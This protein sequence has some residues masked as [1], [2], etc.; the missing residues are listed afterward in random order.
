MFS[1]CKSPGTSYN[2]N[3]HLLEF[4]LLSLPDLKRPTD[5]G[6]AAA[7]A[8]G[9][10]AGAAAPGPQAEGVPG[11]GRHRQQAQNLEILFLRLH[12]RE[13]RVWRDMTRA[14][15]SPFDPEQ[16]V[17]VLFLNT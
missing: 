6:P 14:T 7:A 11:A 4:F 12:V 9:L 3:S 10:E 2:R 17:S 8:L 16:L 15:K 1:C 5:R 13:M